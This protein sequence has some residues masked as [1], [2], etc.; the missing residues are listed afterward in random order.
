MTLPSAHHVCA[1]FVS[2]VHFLHF[3]CCL[4]LLV[5]FLFYDHHPHGRKQKQQKIVSPFH[6]KK[7]EKREREK[8]SDRCLSSWN[9]VKFIEHISVS[10]NIARWW[11]SNVFLVHFWRHKTCSLRKFFLLVWSEFMRCTIVKIPREMMSVLFGFLKRINNKAPALFC[12]HISITFSETWQ[13]ISIKLS[14]AEW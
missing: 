11:V 10:A 8:R 6:E 2:R 3:A 1:L 12:F 5:V 9:G 7:P 4:V 14:T 13:M